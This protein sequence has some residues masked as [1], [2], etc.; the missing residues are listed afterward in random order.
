MSSFIDLFDVEPDYAHN[1]LRLPR[2]YLPLCD[3]AAV[4]AQERL[5]EPGQIV[6]KRVTKTVDLMPCSHFTIHHTILKNR[7]LS[8]PLQCAM[9]KMN[10]STFVLIN[11]Y[12]HESSILQI[13]LVWVTQGN[14]ARQRESSSA[15]L[16]PLQSRSL[17]VTIAANATIRPLSM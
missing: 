16:S 13:L 12:E 7:E 5:A 8:L 9:P 15:C 17:P 11:R 14:W 4:K 3:N 10:W 1:I 2:Y 6:K